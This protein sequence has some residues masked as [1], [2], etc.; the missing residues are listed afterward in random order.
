VQ[1]P[2]I[3]GGSD[4]T[5]S[6]IANGE[7]TM[8]FYVERLQSPNAT[9][10]FALYPTPGV[11]AMSTHTGSPGRA[12]FFED[13][14]E[15]AVIGNSVVEIDLN[16]NITVR[17]TVAVDSNPATISTN[18]DGGGQLFIT[19]G[20]NG[21][22]FD[23]TTN[24]L[25]LVRSG[26]T[27]MGAHL[28]GY[29][30]AIDAATST[31]FLSD[32]L[33]GT[34]WDPTQFAQRS[35]GSDPWVSMKVH[36]RYVWFFG[37][38]TSEV[39][40]NAGT[41][42]FPFAPHPSGLV[43]YGIAAAFSPTK[44]GNS[45][46]W[47]SSTEHGQGS[48]VQTQGFSPQVVSTFAM[49]ADVDAYEQLS[50][51]IGDTYEDLG[52]QFY[53]LSFPR[54]NATKCYD[55]TDTLAIPQ[56]MRWTDRGTWIS[57]DNRYTAWRP[58]YHVFAFN[59]HRILDRESGDIYRMSAAF[60]VDADDRPI[61]RVRRAPALFQSNARVF[62]GAFEVFVEPGLGAVSGQGVNPT[63]ALRTSRDGKTWSA[64]RSR[65]AGALGVYDAR[66]RWERNGS[67]RRWTPE[68]VVTDPVPWRILGAE[69]QALSKAPM[70]Q[71]QRVA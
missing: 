15:F 67:G 22:N 65:S 37:T 35:I 66:L 71:P 17:G 40:Y 61:R 30:L 10:Q 3:I 50:D 14:R 27:T 25:T 55:A 18:G 6:P 24:T 32:L 70:A 8:N 23:L 33:D 44:V 64:E 7:F 21:Y 68:L 48:V 28:D 31:V 9:T 60:G 41:F 54:A 12:H 29:F 53:V 19:S 62:V 4:T 1:Y 69:V 47:L 11:D 38:K 26:A 20:N 59:E 45:L 63:M 52:H 39:W 34:S 46:M 13:G 43:Q 16:G 58:L 56:A 2:G 42:P 51:A 49:H 57:E 5:Q 36:G